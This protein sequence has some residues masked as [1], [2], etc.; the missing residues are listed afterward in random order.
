MTGD[1]VGGPL[2]LESSLL[3][4]S[5]GVRS[6]ELPLEIGELRGVRPVL[7]LDFI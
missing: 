6:C 4:E 2:L 3:P 7:V 5:A 1:G